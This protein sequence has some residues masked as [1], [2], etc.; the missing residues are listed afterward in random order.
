MSAEKMASEIEYYKKNQKWTTKHP[1]QSYTAFVR[2][3][4]RN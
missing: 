4:K 1:S 3:P 2:I